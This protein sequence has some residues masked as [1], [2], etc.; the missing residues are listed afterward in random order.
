MGRYYI[1]DGNMERLEK[2]INAIQKK[3]AKYGTEFRFEKVGE[4]IIE[5]TF[6]KGTEYETKLAYR[7]IIVEAEGKAVINGWK[8]VCEITH[9]PKGNIFRGMEDV[10]I[11]DVYK[12]TTT[13][14]EHCGTVRRRKNT[15]LVQNVETG[16]FKQVGK[17]CLKDYTHG[18][19][20]GMVANMLDMVDHIIEGEQPY[21][22][23][24]YTVMYNTEE[25]LACAVE[26][27]RMY[28]YEKRNE[29]GDWTT[30]ERTHLAWEYHFCG[31]IRYKSNSIEKLIEEFKINNLNPQTEDVQNTVRN[32]LEW[33]QNAEAVGNYMHNAQVIANLEYVSTK[34]FGILVS[35]I[36]C[37]YRHIQKQMEREQKQMEKSKSEHV[38][39]VGKRLEIT[40]ANVEIIARW[41]TSY[42]YGTQSVTVYKITDTEG[43]ELTWK[44]SNYIPEGTKTITG[45]VKEHKEWNGIKQTELTRCKCK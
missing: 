3:C 23:G 17:S 11:P 5:K 8:F 12:T 14:C 29:Y 20:A 32:A 26:M 42:G 18:M 9:T 16:E 45:T 33:M 7:Y 4:E 43:N 41:E 35:I 44:T 15:Y 10:E 13:I 1:L 21:T 37:Y 39:T 30:A 27:V 28:G 24:R 31:G 22:D 19:D 40:V 34:E 36:P 38:G 6:Y 25:I 2:K